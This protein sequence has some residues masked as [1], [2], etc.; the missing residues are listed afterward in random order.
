MAHLQQL[1]AGHQRF[2]SGHSEHPHATGERLR[3]LVE[4]QHPFA[5]ILSCADSRVPVELLFDAGFGDLFVV[6][7]AGTLC[8]GAAIA[9]LEYAVGHLNVPLI[10][11]LGHERC[12]AIETTFHPE[13]RLTPSLSQVI[14]QLRLELFVL[15]A[16]NNLDEACRDHPRNAARNLVDSSVLLTDQIGR[17]H[18]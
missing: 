18:V 8:T 15:G 11:V 2:L 17:A 9:S 16:A 4:G 10:V 6:R 13:L 12:G 7:N 14:G 3:N 1:D 5:A